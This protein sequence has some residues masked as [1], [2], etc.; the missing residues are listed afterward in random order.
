MNFVLLVVTIPLFLLLAQA[1][2]VV[3]FD[4]PPKTV[5][6]FNLHAY[7]G[8]W[9]Q[10]YTSL[11]PSLTYEKDTFCIVADYSRPITMKHHASFD[12]LNSDK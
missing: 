12:I 3:D 8:R 1:L 2:A 4:I 10:V 7:T 11:I 6:E 5:T 9:Y